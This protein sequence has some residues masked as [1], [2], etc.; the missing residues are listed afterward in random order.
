LHKAAL[1]EFYPG[2][3]LHRFLMEVADILTKSLRT[4]KI[5]LDSSEE[6]ISG[7]L[8]KNL[9]D[10]F[11]KGVPFQYLL[12]DSEFYDNH[13]YV[14]QNVLIPRMETELLVDMIVKENQGKVGRVLDIGTGSGVILLSLLSHG[15]GTHGVGSDLSMDALSVADINRKR[16]NLEMKCELIQ[17]DRCQNVTGTFDLIVSN[18]PYIKAL[19]HRGLVHDKVHDFEPHLALYLP[20]DTYSE[21]FKIL[22]EGVLKHLN[23]GGVFYM[24][25]HENELQDQAVVLENLGFVDV[26]VL[27]DLTLRERFLKAYRIK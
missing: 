26:E 7:S 14:N 2:L 17:S 10:A 11:L 8:K 13:F 27:K 15:T 5:S 4:P 6:L 1:E 21:W 23:P 24:E 9:E 19:A 3:N 20:D 25:G 16:L 18:P 22:F 12:E